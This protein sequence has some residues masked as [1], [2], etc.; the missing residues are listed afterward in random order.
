MS[1]RELSMGRRDQGENAGGNYPGV[2]C[3]RTDNDICTV[4]AIHFV[5]V[6]GCSGSRRTFV[7][8]YQYNECD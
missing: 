5:V 3:P 7:N 6:S 1:G 8:M 4:P 2:K